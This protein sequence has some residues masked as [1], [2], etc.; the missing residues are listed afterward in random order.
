MVINVTKE[1]GS[2]LIAAWLIPVSVIRY[3]SFRSWAFMIT[4]FFCLS[5]GFLLFLSWIV[6]VAASQLR[7]PVVS[8]LDCYCCSLSAQ[9]SCCFCPGLLLLQP[10]SSGFLMFLSWIVIVAASQLRFPVVSVLDCYCCS[11]SAQVSCCFCPGLLLLQPLSSGFLLFLSWIV[12]VAASQLRFPVVSV[13]DCYCCSLSPQVSCCFCPVL[14][15]LQPLSSGFLLFLS[16]IVIVAASQLRFPVVSVLYCYCCSL[17]AQVSCCFC[18][19]LLL[20]QP[21]SSGFLLFLSWI[22]NVEASQPG[23]LLFL[24]WIVN[25]AASQPG[26]LLFLSWIVN[27]AASQL[28]FPVVSVLDC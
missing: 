19:G 28:R 27:V 11:L 7:F 1:P 21:L 25:F 22:V 23:F 5:S 18:P 16:W 8:V 24:S 13:L 20:L 14:L 2:L 26:F 12:I 6:I 15:L 3:E 9:V 17:S 10:L 4:I